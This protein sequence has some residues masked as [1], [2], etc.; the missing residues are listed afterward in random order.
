[1]SVSRSSLARTRDKRVPKIPARFDDF[2][3]IPPSTYLRNYLRESQKNIENTSNSPFHPSI[4]FL[5]AGSAATE[6]FKEHQQIRIHPAEESTAIE[7][8]DSDPRAITPPPVSDNKPVSPVPKKQKKEIPT[9]TLK[10]DVITT[11]I[12]P[13]A[14]LYQA[15]KYTTPNMQYGTR[16]LLNEP[17]FLPRS[18]ATI[19]P[20]T[21]TYEQIVSR[22]RKPPFVTKKAEAYL[23]YQD[24]RKLSYILSLHSTLSKIAEHLEPEDLINL[25]AVNKT[26]RA[27]VDSSAL[28][29]RVV[30]RPGLNVNWK[31]FYSVIVDR[32]S[33]KEL[34]LNDYTFRSP[35]AT[36][37]LAISDK[38]I[39][40]AKTLSHLLLPDDGSL[41]NQPIC[42]LGIESTKPEE[43]S[44]ALA[45]ILL[46]YRQQ[47]EFYSK[48]NRDCIRITWRVKVF[49]DIDGFAKFPILTRFAQRILSALPKWLQQLLEERIYLKDPQ[50]THSIEDESKR[51]CLIDAFELKEVIE[52]ILYCSNKANTLR[53][54]II[55]I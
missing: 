15:P 26:W 47:N 40:N 17:I 7:E 48:R 49:I 44:F 39:Q 8:A 27:I 3:E 23:N 30:I 46:L 25:R 53:T 10:S 50:D 54:N 34:V 52:G 1:M 33:T 55:A 28:W 5:T 31:L 51:P 13:G 16:L 18:V 20:I 36:T 35:S 29:Q 14:K 43:N 9:V 6:S 22:S 42:Q 45:L 2:S 21:T 38:I 12:Q 11:T 24:E 41:R 4:T 19:A 32:F 37:E